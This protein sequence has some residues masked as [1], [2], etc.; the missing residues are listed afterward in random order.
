MSESGIDVQTHDQPTKIQP[1]SFKRGRK[2]PTSRPIRSK[3]NQRRFRQRGPKKAANEAAKALI[4]SLADANAQIAAGFR[5]VSDPGSFKFRDPVNGEIDLSYD[6]EDKC[7]D[8]TCTSQDCH[9][10]RA[11]L[12]L[13]F[14]SDDSSEEDDPDSDSSE[15][16]DDGEE[17]LP[18]APVAV[19]KAFS[20]RV[21][22]QLPFWPVFVFCS[23]LLLLPPLAATFLYSG[24]NHTVE[25]HNVTSCSA[26]RPEAPRSWLN[27]YMVYDFVRAQSP[28]FWCRFWRSF[29]LR[30]IRFFSILRAEFDRIF[31]YEP[32]LLQT[33]S[34]Y[35][36]YTRPVHIHAWATIAVLICFY[37]FSSARRSTF[38]IKFRYFGVV[39]FA[40]FFC[41]SIYRLL[42]EKEDSYVGRSF[43][44]ET[45]VYDYCP[46]CLQDTVWKA[47]RFHY[48]FSWSLRE[49]WILIAVLFLC[50]FG[51]DYRIY[52]VPDA[53]SRGAW[54]QMF[55]SDFTERFSHN[56]RGERNA[57]VNA[58]YATIETY[59]TSPFS[60]WRRSIVKWAGSARDR[61]VVSLELLRESLNP[62]SLSPVITK[63]TAVDRIARAAAN[64]QTVNISKHTI[65]QGEDVYGSTIHLAA[66]IR[67]AF[68]DRASRCS[69]YDMLNPP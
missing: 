42:P 1:P 30:N 64:N 69:D 13:N 62:S 15:E 60:I 39:I 50:S 12:S 6:P 55:P 56:K 17:V 49:A 45:V 8:P 5:P 43:S 3:T 68:F 26:L 25:Y 44:N 59:K 24:F 2:I 66:E 14:D 10:R 53:D 28:Y 11:D 32:V 27:P 36:L 18:I 9:A 61:K 47:Q 58:D 54:D 29:E 37:A 63:E 16:S 57:A 41:F 34:T 40:L 4:A 35:T 33:S 19:L 22:G 21:P 65:T 48:D 38:K 67:A 7:P 52:F 51:P 46:D 23:F 20:K 31:G